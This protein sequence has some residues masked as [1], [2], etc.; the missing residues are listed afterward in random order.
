MNFQDSGIII[1]KRSLKENSSII[2][3]FTKNHGLYS[4]LL[5]E[6]KRSKGSIYQ[7]GNYVDF[8]WQARLHEH[9]GYAK[10]ELI[11]AYNAV[12][13]TNKLKLYAFNSL[14]C[15]VKIAFHER[16][17]HNNFFGSL[18]NY[19]SSL[20]DSEFNF[21]NYV[22]L[23]LAVLE[24]AGYHLDLASCAL[25]GSSVDLKYVSPKSGKAVSA[26]AGK[27]YSNKLL[28]LPQFMTQNYNGVINSEE[29]KQ[30]FELT[31]YFFHK[32][33]DIKDS[34]LESRRIFFNHIQAI[35]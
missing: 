9:L 31:T 11:R 35:T 18:F 34:D 21:K 16:E 17:P 20:I 22:N 29:V 12:I 27:P 19:L 25:T 14:V 30:A 1:A 24:E 5:R 2:S 3:V 6:T 23:E 26:T 10:C 13:I 8:F 28:L 33:F 7:P 32:S 4:G 15:L